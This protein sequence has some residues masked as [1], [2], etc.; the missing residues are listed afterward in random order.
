MYEADYVDENGYEEDDEDEDD[1]ESDY[2]S[3][4]ADYYFK[5]LLN[6][7]DVGGTIDYFLITPI[8][9]WN[10]TKYLYDGDMPNIET[11]LEN[12]NFYRLMESTF[13]YGAA[14]NPMA[15][16]NPQTGRATLLALGFVENNN[17]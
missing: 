4:P 9:Y 13:E 10:T 6:Q 14:G 1:A 17:M 3:N 12:Y 7:P 11:L 2:T 5:M 16:G 8:S 15:N